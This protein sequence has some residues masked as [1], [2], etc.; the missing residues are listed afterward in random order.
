MKKQWKQ[1][2]VSVSLLGLCLLT[3]CNNQSTGEPQ[4]S[5]PES[6][7]ETDK[8]EESREEVPEEMVFI[9]EFDSQTTVEKNGLK[10]QYI[11]NITLQE[12]AM[13]GEFQ[14]RNTLTLRSDG[15]YVFQ[16]KLSSVGEPDS[17]EIAVTNDY[18]GTFTRTG[19]E[20]ILGTP[21]FAESDSEWGNLNK[22]I[23]I[24]SE[25]ITSEENPGIMGEFATSFLGHRNL[26][27]PIKASVDEETMSFT[28]E[29]EYGTNMFGNDPQYSANAL[30]PLENSPIQDKTILFLGSSVTFGSHSEEETF[31]EFLSKMDGIHAIKEAVPGTTL[32]TAL[33]KSYVERLQAVNADTKID[34]MLCQ[35][36]TNDAGKRV[37]LGEVSDGFGLDDFDT[38]TVTGAIEYIICYTRETWDCPVI[39][40]TNPKYRSAEYQKMVDILLSLQEKWDIEIVDFWNDSHVNETIRENYLLYMSDAVHPTKAGYLEVFTPA[41]QQ[42]L[43][44]QLAR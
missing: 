38:D 16:K 17:W 43:Y 42:T 5:I 21:E 44:E 30:T 18:H 29:Y 25:H 7:V 36:S 12:G 2:V 8:A 15:S 6:A 22:I 3:G 27:E 19:D 41:I 24:E 32:A 20:V 14:Q 31:V 39:F 37:E 33:E 40:Y 1:I 23:A 13:Y 9:Q 35:L 4:T 34:A 26:P 28:L 10:K 11:Y